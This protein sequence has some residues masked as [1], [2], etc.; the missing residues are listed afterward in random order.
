[1]K[2]VGIL[3]FH[4]ATNYGA[5][6]Q[7][8]ALYKA[9][10][11]LGHQPV[12]VDRQATTI[13]RGEK[14]ARLRYKILSL[15]PDFLLNMSPK[16]KHA[17]VFHKFVKK[18]LPNKTDT[19]FNSKELA[20]GHY[21][22]DYLVVGSDQIWNYKL[23]EGQSAG[24]GLDMFGKF[25]PNETK[26]VSYAASFGSNVWNEAPDITATIKDLV[27]KFS[28]VSV[29]EK[30]GE[31]ICR[32]VFGVEA[33]TVLD[34]TLLAG[35]Q[36]FLPMTEGIAHD[37]DYIFINKF[38]W[39]DEFTAALNES[40]KVWKSKVVVNR[41]R[42][43]SDKYKMVS[44]LSVPEW[45]SMIRHAKIVI[46]DSFHTL[47]FAILFNRP[48]IVV[49]REEE[50]RMGRLTNLIGMLGFDLSNRYMHYDRLPQIESPEFLNID[51]ANANQTLEVERT[52]SLAFLREALEK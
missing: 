10:E 35:G 52:K 45:L 3:T 36:F 31:Q 1:M 21:K 5:V 16:L 32:D 7:T 27:Q 46:T 14:K 13:F 4:T 25:L 17:N 8:Y 44:G 19:Y 50:K 12:I 9:I 49:S 20:E 38:K 47:A 37:D 43:A 39:E 28:A 40:L 34:P 11:G 23:S 42:H 30:S 51:Y 41:A 6:L 26:R 29:R 18:Y 15:C 48:F 22:L 33:Q 2:R 24:M